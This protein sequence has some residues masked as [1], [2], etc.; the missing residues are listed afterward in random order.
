M[1][2]INTSPTTIYKPIKELKAKSGKGNK[3]LKRVD[4]VNF[5]TAKEYSRLITGDAINILKHVS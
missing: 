1:E 5:P 3:K 2:K 4:L